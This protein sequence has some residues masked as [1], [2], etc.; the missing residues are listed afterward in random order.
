[1]SKYFR[2]Q[3]ILAR[4]MDTGLLQDCEQVCVKNIC[5]CCENY[6]IE[7]KNICVAG[8]NAGLSGADTELSHGVSLSLVWK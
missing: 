8:L 7:A 1:M 4:L 2:L 3:F 5:V 6:L